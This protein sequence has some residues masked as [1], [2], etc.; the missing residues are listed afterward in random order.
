MSKMGEI[1]Q[2]LL[3]TGHLS[4]NLDAGLV[5]S[6]FANDQNKPLGSKTRKGYLRTC[7][8]YQGIRICPMIHRIIWIAANGI[9]PEDLL[10]D[11]KNGVKDD[12]RIGNL[13]LVTNAENINRAKLRGA[14]KNCGRKPGALRDSKGRYIH[15]GKKTAGRLLDG[16][17][18]NEWP[19]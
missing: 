6:S 4:V 7:I 14:Y 3:E 12:N 13:E 2:Q 9:V 8:N 1:I 16:R 15:V 5:W 18:W 17:E 19:R 10:V 11:H